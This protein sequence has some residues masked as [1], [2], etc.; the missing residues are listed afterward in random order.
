MRHS[1]LEQA[2]AAEE[3]GAD[4][5]IADQY[6]A[7]AQGA[8]DRPRR[9]FHGDG[10]DAGG[11]GQAAGV[12][13]AEAEAELQHH[14][15]K[16]GKRTG[17]DPEQESAQHAGPE[18]LDA[19]QAE[20]EDRGLQ[21]TRMQD[22]E[23]QRA[24]PDGEQRQHPARRH[25]AAPG[26]LEAEHRGGD[27]DRGEHEA[28]KIEALR[29]FHPNVV[30]VARHQQDP[31]QPD[32]QVDPEYPAPGEIGDEESADRRTDDRSE[33]SG[34]RQIGHRPHEIGLVGGAEQDQPAD[35]HHH[36]AADP[37]EDSCRHQLE[38]GVAD[39][40]ADR[41]QG[42]D[43]DRRPEQGPRADAVGEPAADRD[44]D[45][46]AEEIGADRE[47]EPQRALAQRQGDGRQGGGEHRRIQVLHE[48]G[49][50]DDQRDEDR[51]RGAVG[52]GWGSGYCVSGI[53]G[54]GFGGPVRKY[55]ENIAPGSH[56]R[57][58]WLAHIPCRDGGRC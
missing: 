21:A 54:A 45:R 8:Q 40:A 58:G 9:Q 29:A 33:Q 23:R 19:Q 2:D 52:H 43:G 12:K 41:A 47:I 20:I 7:E 5:G 48:Q 39:A 28:A 17:A 4:Q 31:E 34:H 55:Y 13:G 27:A 53:P 16:E 3:T 56:A 37:L 57:L 46:E 25:E 44:E 35:R 6:R 14:G 30:D 36:R 22:V 15:E 11:E 24:C 38:E 26:Q 1:L 18:G 10:A 51:P 32:R 42:E 50:G 49:A